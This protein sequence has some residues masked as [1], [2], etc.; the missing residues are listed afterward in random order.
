MASVRLFRSSV[1]VAVA[2]GAAVVV[3]AATG[4]VVRISD[5]SSERGGGENRGL[6]KLLY[7]QMSLNGL[8][9]KCDCCY[10]SN[11]WHI[12]NIILVNGSV[13]LKKHHIGDCTKL[14]ELSLQAS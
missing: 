14:F 5:V 13:W 10:W 6:R 11:S 3:G 4:A 1:D 7:W 12:D 9:K 8:K 2:V